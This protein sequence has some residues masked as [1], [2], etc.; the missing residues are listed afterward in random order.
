MIYYLIL[1]LILATYHAW[2]SEVIHEHYERRREDD[3][4]AKAK[5]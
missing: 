1:F 3:R 5:Y 4:Q 2:I